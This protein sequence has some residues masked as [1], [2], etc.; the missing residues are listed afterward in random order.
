MTNAKL[1]ER[2]TII[3]NNMNDEY[4]KFNKELPY[5]IKLDTI[6]FKNVENNKKMSLEEVKA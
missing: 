2:T 3:E 6:Y 1:E 4:N 5:R